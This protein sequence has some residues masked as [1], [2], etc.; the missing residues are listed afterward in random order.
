MIVRRRQWTYIAVGMRAAKR[1]TFNKPVSKR[2]V[3]NYITHQLK[4]I[5]QK[6]WP[7]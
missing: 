5:P 2:Q 4:R 6:V 7:I 3:E 1:L